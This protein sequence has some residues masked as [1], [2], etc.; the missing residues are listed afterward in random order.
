MTDE[1]PP[2]Y[3]TSYPLSGTPER[4]Q[5]RSPRGSGSEAP[6]QIHPRRET[7]KYVEVRVARRRTVAR[8]LADQRASTPSN[9][10][11]LVFC[12]FPTTDCCRQVSPGR[13]PHFVVLKLPKGF[14]SDIAPVLAHRPVASPLWMSSTR[15]ASNFSW[16]LR[17]FSSRMGSRTCSP[18]LR[19]R[20]DRT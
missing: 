17:F 15:S 4:V 10:R 18:T 20:S 9:R 7:G 6:R 5:L 13:F 11:P 8:S 14:R 16:A 2:C 12:G 1:S 19:H 3:L